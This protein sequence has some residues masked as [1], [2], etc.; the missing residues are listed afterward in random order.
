MLYKV[1]MALVE[2]DLGIRSALLPPIT[3]VII[4][5]H[6]SFY[7]YGDIRIGHRSPNRK[8]SAYNHGGINIYHPSFPQEA[9][10]RGVYEENLH[11]NHPYCYYPSIPTHPHPSM[12]QHPHCIIPPH[13]YPRIPPH[14][15]FLC[16]Y[17][18]SSP[19]YETY[20]VPY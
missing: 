2:V 14:Q 16:P 17:W 12:P 8:S 19:R 20:A 6:Q 10:P 18:T 5:D 11:Q 4:V 13:I 9:I 15:V 7:S 1:L 3:Q